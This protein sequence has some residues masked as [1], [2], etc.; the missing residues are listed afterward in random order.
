M[1][2][3]AFTYHIGPAMGFE[4]TPRLR[5]G[6]SLFIT[7]LTHKSSSL[8]FVRLSGEDSTGTNR[9]AYGYENEQISAG[10]IGLK[11]AV[12]LQWEFVRHWHVG[13]VLRSPSFCIYRWGK[14]TETLT[15]NSLDGDFSSEPVFDYRS[16]DLE[17]LGFTLFEPMEV[18]LALGFESDR[19]WIGA[20][21]GI[22][23]PMARTAHC[24]T[25]LLLWNLS[26]G[27]ILKINDM[28]RVGSGFFTDRSPSEDPDVL[29]AMNVDFYGMT[30]GFEFRKELT[31]KGRDS[32]RPLVFST[33]LAVRA[34]LG[35][36]TVGGFVFNIEDRQGLMII[37][38]EVEFL[39]MSLHVGS[40]LYF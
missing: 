2:N 4:V 22:K 20:E 30:T 33:T 34:A 12:G 5:I 38:R 7:Y 9:T 40:A 13:L 8:D 6:F 25:R 36:G 37:P 23:M 11:A 35:F 16:T 29:G 18:A 17:N 21:A 1:Y 26:L 19:G 39:E 3:Q 32:V 27:G 14:R 15:V 28:F 31:V 24:P 10:L